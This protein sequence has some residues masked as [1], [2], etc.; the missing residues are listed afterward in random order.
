MLETLLQKHAHPADTYTR[1][2]LTLDQIMRVF[3]VAPTRQQA[4][5][6]DVPWITFDPSQHHQY[7]VRAGSTHD[8]TLAFTHDTM[9]KAMHRL[10]RRTSYCRTM[11]PPESLEQ[12]RYV[13]TSIWLVQA[14]GMVKLPCSATR[15]YPGLR[16]RVV[17]GVRCEYVVKAEGTP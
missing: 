13:I 10:I 14:H 2:R 11:A 12:I 6:A 16:E 3:G 9:A 17:V 5:A 4:T 1:T 15:L 7:R 8:G